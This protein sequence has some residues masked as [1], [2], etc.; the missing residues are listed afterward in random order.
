MSDRNCWIF[1]KRDCC[2]FVICHL[3]LQR[4]RMDT[5]KVSVAFWLSSGFYSAT[6]ALSTPLPWI[7]IFVLLEPAFPFLVLTS[8]R[9]LAVTTF[10]VFSRPLCS[11][12]R[13]LGILCTAATALFIAVKGLSTAPK[14]CDC[15]S[16]RFYSS[17]V[18]LLEAI[19]QCCSSAAP[20]V[21]VWLEF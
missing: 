3:V 2:R 14:I 13:D 4:V 11:A 18:A 9:P 5:N 20:F 7:T 6:K 8:G 12:D 21:R 19:L 17:F 1:T 15:C 10:F 16:Q